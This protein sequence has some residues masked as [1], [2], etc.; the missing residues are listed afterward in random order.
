MPKF[1][2]ILKWKWVHTLQNNSAHS[3]PAFSSVFVGSY[4]ITKFEY[5]LYT[6]FGPRLSNNLCCVILYWYWDHFLIGGIHGGA[7]HTKTNHF[8]KN[9][10]ITPHVHIDLYIIFMRDSMVNCDLCNHEGCLHNTP[11]DMGYHLGLDL[12]F[13][14]NQNG[15]LVIQRPYLP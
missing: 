8:G 12:H 9:F 11:H 15:Y 2:F 4:Y 5:D 7:F 14:F 1:Y 6:I 13:Q 3:H 10:P